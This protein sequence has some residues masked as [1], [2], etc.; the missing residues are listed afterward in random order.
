MRRCFLPGEC[1]GS[2][3]WWEEP[4]NIGTSGSYRT[5]LRVLPSAKALHVTPRE[6]CLLI[7]LIFLPASKHTK[8]WRIINTRGWEVPCVPSPTSGFKVLV[9]VQV[10][11]L[12]LSQDILADQLEYQN[13]AWTSSWN[14]HYKLASFDLSP[15]CRS[16]SRDTFMH[17]S[18]VMHI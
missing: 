13:R 12:S 17:K 9:L 7:R 1:C 3:A 15:W 4:I 2:G 14:F 16:L 8:T 10:R 11:R 18:I 5:R 6:G